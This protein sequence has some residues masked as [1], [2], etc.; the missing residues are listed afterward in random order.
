MK[1]FP[2]LLS[3]V[4]SKRPN[5]AMYGQVSHILAVNWPPW[6]TR[7]ST[8]DRKCHRKAVE[9]GLDE[10]NGKEYHRRPQIVAGDG[11]VKSP[12]SPII[13]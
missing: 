11:K 1:A 5:G 13:P 7:V 3:Q 6:P 9:N 10:Q 2:E 12:A 4:S 8:L